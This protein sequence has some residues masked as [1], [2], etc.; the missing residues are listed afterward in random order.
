M[1]KLARGPSRSWRSAFVPTFNGIVEP[2][3]INNNL[4]CSFHSALGFHRST[5]VTYEVLIHSDIHLCSW[6]ES[7]LMSWLWALVVNSLYGRKGRRFA[8]LSRVPREPHQDVVVLTT[9]FVE[10]KVRPCLIFVIKL[11]TTYLLHVQVVECK[12][13]KCKMSHKCQQIMSSALCALAVDPD[14][15]LRRL[16]YANSR[17]PPF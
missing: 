3:S 16:E 6:I 8:M 15:N 13:R 2:F 1:G 5:A 11:M 10:Q 17:S 4:H 7:L 9:S 12:S 14:E